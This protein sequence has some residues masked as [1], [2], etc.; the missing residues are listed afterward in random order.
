VDETSSP[1]IL[2]VYVYSSRKDTDKHPVVKEA[3]C[4]IDTGNHQGN[5]VSR[6]FV[7]NVLQFPE[8]NFRQLSEREKKGAIGITGSRFIPEAAIYLTWYHK[9]S[10]RVFRDMRFL[11]TPDQHCDLIIGA[12]SI[13]ANQLLDVPNLVARSDGQDGH[14]GRT[15]VNGGPQGTTNFHTG[16]NCLSILTA[17]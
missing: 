11:I 5:I 17:V 2:P 8:A 10:T 3:K 14:L 15:V 16:S 4:T 13:Q 12:Y 6:D 7:L 1:W 9:K